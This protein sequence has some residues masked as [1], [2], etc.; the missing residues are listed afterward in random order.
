MDTPDGQWAS[1]R[2]PSSRPASQKSHRSSRSARSQPSSRTTEETPLLAREGRTDRSEGSD[3][4]DD[5]EPEHTPATTSLLRSLSGSSETGPLKPLWKRRWPSILALIILCLVVVII[6]LGFLTTEAV[7]EYA[8]QA[9]DFHPT[10]LSLDSLT[11]TGV[12]VR[13]QGLFTM[14]ASKVRKTSVRNIGRLG[15]WI[16]REVESEATHVDLYL[17][18]YGT[19]MVGTARVPGI[20]VNIRNRH[21]THLSFFADLDPGSF[22]NIRNIANDWLDGRLGQIRIKGKADVPLKSGLIP[23][24]SQSIEESLVFQGHDLPSLPRYDITKF[25]IREARNGSHGMGADFSILVT[26][27]YPVDF[28]IPPVSVDV[29]VDGCV[30]SDP[31]IMVGTAA[32][33]RVHVEPKVDMQVNVTGKVESLPEE[34]TAECPNSLKS[35]LDSFIGNYMHGEGSTVYIKCCKFPDPETPDWT[36]ALLRDITVPV[37]FAGRDM[38]NLIKNFSL[39]D[40]HFSFPDLFAD[41]D[42]PEAQPQISAL[43]KVEVGLPNEMNFPLNVTGIG[44]NAD[45]FYHRKKF[46]KLHLTRWQAANSTRI[47]AHGEEGP[48]LL[49]EADIKDAPLEILDDDVFS[50]VVKG[51]VLGGR[52]ITLDIKA[53]MDVEV[54]TPIGK[55][56]VREIPAEGVVPVKP[57]G[58]DKGGKGFGALSP[59]IYN[60]TIMDTSPTGVTLQA[61]VNFTNPTKY[62]ATVPY[63]NINILVNDTILGQA[64]AK[65]VFVHPGNNTNVAVTAVYDP[66]TNSGRAGKFIGKE[67]LSQYISGYNTSL[68]LQTHN[69]TI[70]SQPSLGFALSHLPVT[71]PTPRLHGPKPPSD[72]NDPKDP[73]DDPSNDDDSP[74][75]IR[76]ATMHLI[77]STAVF[78]LASPLSTTTLYITN[79]NATAFYDGNPSGKILYE[80]PFAVPPGLSMTPRL[81][82]DWSLGSVGYEAIKKALGGTLKL[83]AYAD[84]SVRI[85]RW[86]QDIWFRGGAIGANVRL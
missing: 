4:A 37:P 41:P 50:E 36:R 27:E 10:K 30:P 33:E 34:L 23:L 45:V 40:V 60:L 48:S 71:L 43:V 56:A 49:V 46:G 9:A 51:I 64:T 25:N 83:S 35:P 78:T 7:Q 77:S 69:G 79:L 55:F 54:N 13:V 22:D 17:P 38:G 66:I 28:S 24:G 5:V 81:P 44:A 53:A 20:K 80:L 32:T 74:H 26:N 86:N 15:A 75:F 18:E 52:P 14:D 3:E 59:R 70:P 82:V 42:S 16:A 84:V 73:N 62:S 8:I 57:V 72:G 29:L 47:E 12:R 2:T 63:F 67:L 21:T 68:T 1:T 76:D 6:M 58:H 61:L 19:A 11:D 39:D 65:N 85:G 31:Y